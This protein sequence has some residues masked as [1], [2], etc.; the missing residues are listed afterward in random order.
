VN[1]QYKQ[2]AWEFVKYMTLDPRVQELWAKDTGDF[3]TSMSVINQIKGSFA[4]PQLG[5]QNHYEFFAR[6]A[7][8]IDG[9]LLAKYDLDIRNF[10]M[11][12]VH[13]YT[14]GRMTKDEA[15]EQFKENVKNAFPDVAVE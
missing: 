1:S 10:L 4:D 3:I 8:K 12:A 6:E 13:E 7:L 9:R 5:G 11:G 14:S 15:L 2:E